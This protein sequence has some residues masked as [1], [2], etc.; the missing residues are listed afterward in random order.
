MQLVGPELLTVCRVDLGTMGQPHW[1][2]D[3]GS[4]RYQRQQQMLEVRTSAQLSSGC[5]TEV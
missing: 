2:I 1:L 3:A 4:H 5:V